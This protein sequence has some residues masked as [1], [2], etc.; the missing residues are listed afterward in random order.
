MLSAIGSPLV[1]GSPMG[2]DMLKKVKVLRAFYVGRDVQKAGS[3]IELDAALAASVVASNKAEFFKEE[4]KA[5][6]PEA[7]KSRSSRNAG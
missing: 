2:K 1:A 4:P 7:P 3:I 5:A 6:A